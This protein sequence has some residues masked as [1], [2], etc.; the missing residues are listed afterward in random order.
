M[1]CG[2]SCS[3]L[4][5]ALAFGASLLLID[6]IPL[7]AQ[8]TAAAITGQVTDESGAVLPGVT[9]TVTGPALQVPQITTVTEARGEYRVT[10]LPIGTYT[11]VYSL[12]GFQTV[13][14]E[15]VR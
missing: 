10:P 14:R 8:Q 3:R 7:A 1:A 11:V 12:T 2:T 4:A 6:S 5:M 9:V 13:R 15:N